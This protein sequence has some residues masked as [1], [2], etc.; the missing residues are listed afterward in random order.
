[1]KKIRK[2]SKKL[3]REKGQSLV[4]FAVSLVLILTILAGIC[5]LGRMF[6]YYIAMRDAAQ[7]GALYGSAYP[8]N[9][10]EIVARAEALL[11]GDA[12]VNVD[13][14]EKSCSEAKADDIA[15]GAG[16]P[17]DGCA[18]KTIKV[19]VVD[20]NFDLTMPF[21]GGWSIRLD[22]SANGTILRPQ[23]K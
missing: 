14:N 21:F 23:C 22:A 6:F 7:E 9:C 18:S 4:E 2:A 13:I 3:K 10:D 20:E 12:T 11:S 8:A 19:S 17:K 15:L 16:G 5:D 1:M